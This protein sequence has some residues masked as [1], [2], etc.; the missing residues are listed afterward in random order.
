MYVSNFI[1]TSRLLLQ[2]ST[3]Y[4][5]L[6]RY[7]LAANPTHLAYGITFLSKWLDAKSITVVVIQIHPIKI[8]ISARS[9]SGCRSGVKH[10]C[11]LLYSVIH[12]HIR[13]SLVS[14]EYR[15]VRLC[16]WDMYCFCYKMWDWH[17]LSIPLHKWIQLSNEI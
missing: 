16:P 11:G 13:P 6:V 14:P 7:L 15:K 9:H 4:K 17:E 3:L 2:F 10:T 12:D 1:L 8:H 5:K